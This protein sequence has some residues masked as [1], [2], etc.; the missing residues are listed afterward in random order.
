MKPSN[1]FRSCLFLLV[2]CCILYNTHLP[3]KYLSQYSQYDPYPMFSGED[4]HNFLYR[5]LRAHMKGLDTFDKKPEKFGLAL[6][7]FGQN[8]D[9]AKTYNSNDL[10]SPANIAGKWSMIGLIL[11]NVPSGKTLPPLLEEAKNALDN[12]SVFPPNNIDRVDP[13]QLCG[14]LDVSA[15]FKNRGFRF[16]WA[17]QIYEDFGLL[18]EGG[19]SSITYEPT[20]FSDL[21]CNSNGMCSCTTSMGDDSCTQCDICTVKQFLTCR[22]EAIAQELGLDFN[23][24]SRTS[25]QDLRM[26]GY[27][28]HAYEINFDKKTWPEFLLM[29]FAIL[30][31]SAAT[32]APRNPEKFFS[33]SAGNNGHNSIGF[34]GGLSVDFIETIE[35]AAE[36]GFAH[37]FD[38]NIENYRVPTSEGQSSIFPFSTS[39]NVRPGTNWHFAATLNAPH[40][41]DKLSFYFQYFIV[42]HGKDK[43]SLNN[44]DPAFKP[45]VLEK[46][47]EWRFQGANIA[48]N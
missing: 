36:G 9:T 44:P 25:F 19:V 10:T 48:F 16:N 46:I 26:H 37:F 40:F 27:W 5:V 14:Y 21:T 33:L 20:N 38:R 41:I 13:K 47:S 22:R 17:L 12:S 35:I 45:N 42:E 11:G 15:K 29:P 39:V 34:T 23:E 30:S 24:F 43:I 7:V 18:I 31:G 6:S 2:I 8:A 1:F 4:T 3:A 28:R 32:A